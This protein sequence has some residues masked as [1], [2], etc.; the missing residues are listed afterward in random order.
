MSFCTAP[1]HQNRPQVCVENREQVKGGL[2]YPVGLQL[3]LSEYLRAAKSTT[4]GIF[5]K[6]G[7]AVSY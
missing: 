6:S 1:E 3:F 2:I 4:V 7:K 5:G